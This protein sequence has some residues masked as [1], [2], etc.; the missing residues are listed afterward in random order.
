[1]KQLYFRPSN[2]QTS[3]IGNVMDTHYQRLYQVRGRLGHRGDAMRIYDQ[4]QRCLAQI[5][6]T[7]N[8]LMP[9]FQLQI[10]HQTI[11]TFG[12]SLYFRELL[13]INHLNWVVLVNLTQQRYHINHV[14]RTLARARPHT[15]G[16]LRISINDEQF[17]SVLALVIIFLDRRQQIGLPFSLPRF[18]FPTQPRHLGLEHFAGPDMHRNDHRGN[19]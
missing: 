6:Q 14:N 4:S 12:V 3:L 9:K 17:T 7:T 11:G 8:G 13:F 1:M 2:H 18:Y 10:D 16:L 15:N 5:I 19:I